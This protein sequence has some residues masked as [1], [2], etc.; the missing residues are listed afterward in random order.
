MAG[1]SMLQI[2]L[3]RSPCGSG[4]GTVHAEVQHAPSGSLGTTA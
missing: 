1:V 4:E 2:A 3:R